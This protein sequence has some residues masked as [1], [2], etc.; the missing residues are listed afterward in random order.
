MTIDPTASAVQTHSLGDLPLADGTTLR[1][2]KIV[3]EVHGMLH[4]DGSN[5]VVFPTFFMGSHVENRWLIV[6]QR[7]LDPNRYCIVVPNLIGNG[8]ST[9]PSNAT[10][11]QRDG[12][13]PY[14]SYGDQVRAQRRL[15]DELFGV[16]T[17]H[18][19]V[20]WSMGASQAL[21][22]AVAFPAFVERV[23]AFCGSAQ[24]S[25]HNVVFLDGVEAAIRADSTL[26]SG[27]PRN[28][29]RA[30]ARV[31]AGWGFS[32]EFYAGRG[33][34]ALGF[35]SLELFL[36]GFWD[37]MLLARDPWDLIAMM[38]TWRR[39]DVGATAGTSTES[40]LGRITASPRTM[41]T[42]TT[43]WDG[44]SRTERAQGGRW[45][46]GASGMSRNQVFAA[47]ADPTR[48]AIL[49]L[50]RE[51]EEVAVGDIAACFRT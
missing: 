34:R 26:G 13:F 28:G 18:A 41:R 17:A 15:V 4:A 33:Y 20:G 50:L 23:F 30:A 43:R 21:H 47:V 48:R 36:Q 40:A 7:S 24:T 42:S 12:Q 29:M 37:S 8:M 11:G 51:R 9:S 35:D 39:G 45:G 10:A 16:P 3:Y 31:Y 19:F 46:E 14:V 27:F 5:L 32:G 44:Y 49:T 25:D 38:T 6:P 22:W 2:A 1:D